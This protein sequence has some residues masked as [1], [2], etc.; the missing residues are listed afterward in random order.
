MQINIHW[1]NSNPA[2]KLVEVKVVGGFGSTIDL[3][4]FDGD[5]C[6]SL[7]QHLRD[8]AFEIDPE[9]NNHD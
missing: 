4:L 1:V 5:E 7:A 2:K 8:V 3:G 9:E 6:R